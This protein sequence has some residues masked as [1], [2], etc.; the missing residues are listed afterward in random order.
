MPKVAEAL[1]LAIDT[2]QGA[3][4]S[5]QGA[6]LKNTW[7]PELGSGHIVENTWRPEL[8]SGRV[9]ENTWRPKLRSGRVGVEG[10]GVEGLFC[11]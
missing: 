5:G 3:L 2:T 1:W 8:R 6:S 4:N 7:R 9:V 10:L 11:S